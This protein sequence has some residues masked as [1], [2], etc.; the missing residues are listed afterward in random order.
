MTRRRRPGEHQVEKPSPSKRRRRRSELIGTSARDLT[1]AETVALNEADHAATVEAGITRGTEKSRLNAARTAARFERWLE[2]SGT[3]LDELT[4]DLGR[5]RRRLSGVWLVGFASQIARPEL[6]FRASHRQE[7]ANV[8]AGLRAWKVEVAGWGEPATCAV[9]RRIQAR[10]PIGVERPAQA[11]LPSDGTLA[12]VAAAID[13]LDLTEVQS[14]ALGALHA[15]GFWGGGRASELVRH[16]RWRHIVVNKDRTRLLITWPGGC[17]FQAEDVTLVRGTGLVADPLEAVERLRVALIAEG[18][19][20]DGD[21]TILPGWRGTDPVLSPC[22]N[23][24]D[25]Y[26]EKHGEFAEAMMR[27]LVTVWYRDR[28]EQAA[29]LAGLTGSATRRVSLHGLRRGLATAAALAGVPITEIQYELRHG[30][31]IV[32]LRYTDEECVDMDAVV[33]LIELEDDIVPVDPVIVAGLAAAL[34]AGGPDD[35][36]CVVVDDDEQRCTRDAVRFFSDWGQVCGLHESRI[37]SGIHVRGPVRDHLAECLE[38]DDELESDQ[39]PDLTGDIG[40]ACAA[41]GC[42]NPVKWQRNLGAGAFSWLCQDHAR[43]Q[44]LDPDGDWGTLRCCEGLG[45]ELT[46][47]QRRD[48]QPCGALMRL[49]V[50]G[51]EMQLCSRCWQAARAA[52]DRT[53]LRSWSRRKLVG[54][55]VCQFCTDTT[56]ANGWISD[57]DHKALVCEAH[58]RRW[59]VAGRPASLDDHLRAPIDRRVATALPCAWCSDGVNAAGWIVEVDTDERFAVCKSHR[60]RWDAAGRPHRLSPQLRRPV[61]RRR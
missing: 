39:G 49:E 2:A 60:S 55:A 18:C 37:R 45:C 22:E 51:H 52:K 44:A 19:A 8:V 57:G 47:G 40:R 13:K 16:L 9:V 5:G 27:E 33:R 28:W 6:I 58:Q 36:C 25:A 53:N 56:A 42:P 20:P 4:E 21:D 59:F 30:N 3:S 17:K 26:R 48:G 35:G 14:A 7:M 24:E 61:D 38:A 50:G 34:P 43:A 41:A 11:I 10:L 1:L 46:Y 31:W 29:A 15:L 32:T 23:I 12:A 54:G